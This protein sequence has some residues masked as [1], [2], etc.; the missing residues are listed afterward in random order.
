MGARAR[1]LILQVATAHHCHEPARP[2]ACTPC[3]CRD[4]V[5]SAAG[6]ELDAALG[7]VVKE[8]V[9]GGEGAASWLGGVRPR[10]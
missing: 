3:T 1:A 4:Q 5:G 10:G 8:P 9:Q 2:A 6:G 7:G